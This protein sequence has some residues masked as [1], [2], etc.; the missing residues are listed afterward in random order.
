MRSWAFWRREA[1]ALELLQSNARK[2]ALTTAAIYLVFHIL[3]TLGWPQIFSPRIWAASLLMAL[4]TTLTLQ[5]LERNYWLS[6]FIWLTGLTL[7]VLVLYG[8]Y[9]HA[10]IILLLTVLPLMAEVTIGLAGTLVLEGLLV[11]LA[12]NLWRLP[13]LPWLPA[14]YDVL[15]TLTLLASGALGWGLSDNLMSATDAAFYHYREALRR[16]EETRA[17]RAE[18]SVLLREQNKAN[19]QLERL[20]ALL[21]QARLRAEEARQERDR[22]ALAVSH[23]L[24]SPLNFIIGF[25]DLMVNSP[26]TYAPLPDWPPG[27]HEDVQQIYHSSKHLLG[28]IN[29]ILDMGKMDAQQM[30]LLREPLDFSTVLTEVREMVAGQVEK[31][32]LALRI[33]V[34]D[35][36]PPVWLDRTRIRQVLLNLVSNA[37]RFTEQGQIAIR[38]ERQG[39]D[40]LHVAVSD[41]GTGIAPADQEKI[42]DEFRQVGMTNWRRTEGSGLGLAI[43]RRFVELHGGQMGV[44]SAPGSGTT[45]W[46]TLPLRTPVEDWPAEEPSAATHSALKVEHQSARLVLFLASDRFWAR[47]FG[48]TLTGYQVVVFSDPRQ[49]PELVQQLYPRAVLLDQTLAAHPSVIEFLRNPPYELP[50]I[51]LAVPVDLNRQTALPEGVRR[52]LVKPVTRLDLVQAVAQ[53]GPD[54]RRLLVVDD[55]PAMVRFVTQT[56]RSADAAAGYELCTALTGE[57]ALAE[58]QHGGVDAVLLDLELPDV[59][60]LAVLEAAR[61]MGLPVVIVSANDLPQTLP[62][63]QAGEL[64]VQVPRPLRRAELSQVVLAVV[65]TITPQLRA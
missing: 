40:W 17:H 41:T 3:A 2:V 25:S 55:D 63:T 48:E 47:S 24:R 22:F 35:D 59:S 23:E 43:G 34:E 13:G 1:E 51:R 49:L 21:E 30:T 37:L 16:L 46:F 11:A 54:V 53:L 28:L 58:L 36:L 62:G 12:L 52:Y 8:L 31:K 9:G 18:I 19:Y 5:L 45:I 4:V 10:E 56:L 20:N 57:Q 15:L 27:L 6:Q 60:G 42:F 44:Q 65:E 32:G 14:G 38:A 7:V 29:D 61:G 64:T 50:L 33:E 26:E 39:Q